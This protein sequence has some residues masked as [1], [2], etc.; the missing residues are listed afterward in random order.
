[1]AWKVETY[2]FNRLREQSVPVALLIVLAEF[3]TPVLD[4][5]TKALDKHCVDS[6]VQ[7][8]DPSVKIAVVL[9]IEVVNLYV[10]TG[11]KLSCVPSS[12]FEPNGLRT[13]PR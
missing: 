13:L 8:S 7:R 5:T 9:K 10:N 4:S 6:L 3:R 1:M 2:L 12:E 11:V